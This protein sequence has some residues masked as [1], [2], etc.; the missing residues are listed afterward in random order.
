LDRVIGGWKN[1]VLGYYEE[2]EKGVFGV[3]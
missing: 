3:A 2:F 1:R